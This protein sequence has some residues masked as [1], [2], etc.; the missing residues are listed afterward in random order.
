MS[1]RLLFT[2]TA[3]KEYKKISDSIKPRIKNAF[4]EIQSNPLS[5]KPLKGNLA[6]RFSYRVGDYRIVYVPQ[7]KDGAIWILY[8]RHRRDA[9]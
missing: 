7:K 2:P 1:W 3:E 9:Y 4:L 8:V 5:G 6:G